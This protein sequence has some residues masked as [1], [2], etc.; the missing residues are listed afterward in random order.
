MEPYGE[1][2]IQVPLLQ[3]VP[4]SAFPAN[5]K[6]DDA[7]RE[8]RFKVGG[9]ECASCVVSIEAALGNL[10]G[11]KNVSVSPLKGDA[12]VRYMPERISVSWLLVVLVNI[13]ANFRR[14]NHVTSSPDA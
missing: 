4:S 14:Y 12:S 5:H 6:G 3:S 7:V 1:D 2:E 8:L 11:I 10:D 13:P 9:I